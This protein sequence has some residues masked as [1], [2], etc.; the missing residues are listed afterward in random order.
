MTPNCYLKGQISL[1]ELGCIVI[2]LYFSADILFV[3]SLRG[4]H[5][6]D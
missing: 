5:Q 3:D 1:L 4:N 6:K 2:K